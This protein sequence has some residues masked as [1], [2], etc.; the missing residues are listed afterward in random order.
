[1]TSFTL[2]L[3]CRLPCLSLCGGEKGRRLRLLTPEGRQRKPDEECGCDE[4]RRSYTL[5]I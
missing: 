5:H 3:V 4:K 2:L 1:M